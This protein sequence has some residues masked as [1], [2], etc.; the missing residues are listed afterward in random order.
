MKFSSKDLAVAYA[1]KNS[2]EYRVKEP[3]KSKIKPKL[4]SDNFSYDK[5]TPWTH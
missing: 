3:K 2:I 1:E 5:K 4:Y